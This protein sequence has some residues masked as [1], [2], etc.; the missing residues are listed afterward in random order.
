MRAEAVVTEFI[1][2]VAPFVTVQASA[3]WTAVSSIWSGEVFI[4]E[5]S[6]RFWK[7]TLQVCVGILQL[8]QELTTR[9]AHQ[10]VQIMAEQQYAC[11]G[12]GIESASG[13][14]Y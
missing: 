14:R 1:S 6:H 13:L 11:P 4:P 5:L 8:E 12:A 2:A 10:S 3:V 7:L 9:A